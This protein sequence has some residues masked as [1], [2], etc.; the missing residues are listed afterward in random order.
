MTMIQ[1]ASECR[2]I[3][4]TNS[5]RKGHNKFGIGFSLDPK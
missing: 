1:I 3:M 2:A 4:H 5:E